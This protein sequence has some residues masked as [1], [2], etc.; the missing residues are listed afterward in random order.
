MR[1]DSESLPDSGKLIIRQSRA[2]RAP[3]P[4][5]AARAGNPGTPIWGRSWGSLGA[6]QVA[7]GPGAGAKA[8]GGA[9]PCVVVTVPPQGRS[10]PAVV[11]PHGSAPPYLTALI[12]NSCPVCSHVRGSAHAPCPGDPIWCR[13]PLAL[14]PAPASLSAAG[15]APGWGQPRP[16]F[17]VQGGRWVLVGIT[18][19][20][21]KS[22]GASGVPP[23]IT[24]TRLSFLSSP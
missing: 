21:P 24:G 14:A 7:E 2:P 10:Q 12:V 23:D 20:S 4:P 22:L 6:P 19:G 9:V 11:S 1:L 17:W 16:P 18:Q 5:R 15:S 13:K 3:L 8:R